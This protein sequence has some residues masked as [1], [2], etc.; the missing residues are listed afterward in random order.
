VFVLLATGRIWPGI[1]WLVG[2]TSSIA[3][4]Q[5]GRGDKALNILIWTVGLA[6][7]FATKA[8]WPGILVLVFL[9]MIVNGRGRSWW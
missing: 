9:S 3:A 5:A 8:F 4:I 2:I 6:L 7:L 1:L